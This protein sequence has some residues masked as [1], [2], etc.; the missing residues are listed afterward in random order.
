M[1]EIRMKCG[2]IQFMQTYIRDRGMERKENRVQ[3]IRMTSGK[4]TWERMIKV[5]NKF[6]SVS[7]HADPS[8]TEFGG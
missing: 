4:V 7:L 1:F 5:H 6:L 8:R 3:V 2:L